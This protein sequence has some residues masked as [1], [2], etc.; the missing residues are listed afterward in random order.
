MAEY[1]NSKDKNGKNH[2]YR[3]EDSKKYAVSKEEYENKGI[4]SKETKTHAKQNRWTKVHK[5][6]D[7]NFE[8]KNNVMDITVGDNRAQADVLYSTRAVRTF[9]KAAYWL[10]RYLRNAGICNVADIVSEDVNSKV[11]AATNSDDSVVVE[12]DGWVCTIENMGNGD[13]KAQLSW[14]FTLENAAVTAEVIA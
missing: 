9:E 1:I 10:L 14:N 8:V 4:A 7:G 6:G 3:V 2:Y 11:S 13:F 12:G 5:Q